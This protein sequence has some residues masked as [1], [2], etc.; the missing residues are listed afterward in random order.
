MLSMLQRKTPFVIIQLILYIYS[1]YAAVYAKFKTPFKIQIS[2]FCKRRY[3]YAGY[4]RLAPQAD[5]F[6]NTLAGSLNGFGVHYNFLPAFSFKGAQYIHQGSR[7]H[8]GAN[9]VFG[10]GEEPLVRAHVLQMLD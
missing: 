8:I 4:F 3:G 10:Q 2:D 5:H 6:V 1:L 9:Q 7:L